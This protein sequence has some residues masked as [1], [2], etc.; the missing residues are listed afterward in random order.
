MVLEEPMTFNLKGIT[1][2]TRTPKCIG[3][4]RTPLGAK[5]MQST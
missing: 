2:M 1:I 5:D 4:A 3:A